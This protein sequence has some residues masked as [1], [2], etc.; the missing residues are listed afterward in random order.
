M[1]KG[2]RTQDHHALS[3]ERGNT[4]KM[5]YSG[6]S[7]ILW[8]TREDASYVPCQAIELGRGPPNE[9]IAFLTTK[10]GKRNV[11]RGAGCPAKGLGTLYVRH[12]TRDGTPCVWITLDSSKR[13]QRDSFDARRQSNR[14]SVRFISVISHFARRSVHS[15]A[16]APSRRR[17]RKCYKYTKTFDTYTSRRLIHATDNRT[18]GLVEPP[19]RASLGPRARSALNATTPDSLHC[20]NRSISVVE[21]SF[22]THGRNSSVGATEFPAASREY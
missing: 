19:G 22:W 15:K 9:F 11:V 3:A 16:I 6:Y 4:K 14:V 21:V 8:H 12:R 2:F 20:S 10:A 13:S 5:L 18:R 17:R 7:C 1:R